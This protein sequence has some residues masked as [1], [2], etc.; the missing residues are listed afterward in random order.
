MALLLQ[1]FFGS[2]LVAI[3]ALLLL[4]VESGTG[5]GWCESDGSKTASPSSSSRPA[6]AHLSPT[7]PCHGVGALVTHELY[8]ELY[9]NRN[10]SFYTYESFL[11]AARSFPTFGTQGSYKTR[12]REI[13]AFSAHV[14]LETSGLFYVEEID[15]SFNYC[16]NTSIQ[17]P[18]APGQKYFGRGPLQLSWNY[19]Y[20][21]ASA[22][23]G[24]N[25]LAKPYLVSQDPVL[26]FKS[27][28][29]FW[30]TPSGTIPSIHEVLIGKWKPSKADRE[31]G[32]KPGFGV[33][34]DIINGGLEC[35]KASP[36]PQY[37]IIYFK[38]FCKQLNVST[39]PNLSCA[40]MQ[41]F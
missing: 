31:A 37:R 10:K 11:D 39:G 24:A 32:R 30:T 13:A 16:D 19:N 2:I 25:I 23:V 5:G 18:C 26:A 35:G 1:P 38:E 34:I 8:D 4:L 6:V 29:W 12:L 3:A 15:Q 41:P 17:Y 20:G 7:T 9:P 28:L 33:T 36:H 21:A 14:Q 22:K 27:S 40:N